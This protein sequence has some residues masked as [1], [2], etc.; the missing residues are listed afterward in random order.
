M[1]NPNCETSQP[2]TVPRG[3]RPGERS[4]LVGVLLVALVI[5]ASAATGV[6]VAGLGESQRPSSLPSGG[7]GHPVHL[8][9]EGMGR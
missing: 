9:R 6:L 5:G 3:N 4:L 1:R 2:T 8:V 7:T